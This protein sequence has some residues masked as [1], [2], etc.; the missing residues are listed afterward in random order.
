M[1]VFNL[2]SVTKRF[3]YALDGATAIEYGLIAAMISMGI[4]AA[5][6]LFGDTLASLFYSG[7]GTVLTTLVG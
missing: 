4:M 1:S 7:L 5:V 2:R 6:F 3:F